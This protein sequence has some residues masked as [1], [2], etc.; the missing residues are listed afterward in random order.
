M[1][2][3]IKLNRNSFINTLK[4]A[5]K[6]INGPNRR[7]FM[8]EVTRD[9]FAGN[10]RNAERV[11]GW[12][13]ETIKKGLHELESGLICFDA[14]SS[15]GNKR[16]EDK[17]PKLKELIRAIAERKTLADPSLK[18]RLIYTKIT[19]KGLSE[20]LQKEYGYR[21]RIFRAIIHSELY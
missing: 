18:S 13:R 8:A 14:Y 19:T 20:V 17:D 12:G 11:L 10:A 3:K 9:H 1:N 7:R 5:S 6:N 16:F 21:P 15:R 2:T 4:K